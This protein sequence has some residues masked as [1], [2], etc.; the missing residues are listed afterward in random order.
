[1]RASSALAFLVG[2]AMGAAAVYLTCTEKGRQTLMKGLDFL[3]EKIKS[4]TGKED[5]KFEPESE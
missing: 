5:V 2:G 1:M 4:A 3:D